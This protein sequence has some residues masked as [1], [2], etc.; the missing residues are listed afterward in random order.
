MTVTPGAGPRL[1]GLSQVPAALLPISR[2][3][4]RLG[5]SKYFTAQGITQQML[6]VLQ[7]CRSSIHVAVPSGWATSKWTWRHLSTK[8]PLFTA[9]RH[10]PRAPFGNP[11][12][13][14]LLIVIDP[15]RIFECR[16]SVM[17]GNMIIY[18]ITICLS[19]PCLTH[20]VHGSLWITMAR[21]SCWLATLWTQWFA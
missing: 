10:W 3:K 12:V 17:F 16:I 8:R 14:I 5:S 2:A 9:E 7:C 11:H 13:Q 19:C 21:W 15:D 6:P 4:N 1:P 18:C 20:R